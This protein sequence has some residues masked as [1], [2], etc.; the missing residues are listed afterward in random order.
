ML[1]FPSYTFIPTCMFIKF[2]K[3]VLPT[4]LFQPTC[5][6]GTLG[7]ICSLTERQRSQKQ[8]L[9][10]TIKDIFGAKYYITPRQKTMI[11]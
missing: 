3:I 2:D 4:R 8:N 11:K 7:Y 5:L 10:Q 6:F 9:N 1:D